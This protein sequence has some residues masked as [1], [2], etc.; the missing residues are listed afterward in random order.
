M[1]TNQHHDACP[2]NSP[3]HHAVR[4]QTERV[5][6]IWVQAVG[7]GDACRRQGQRGGCDLLGP[8]HGA[9][10]PEDSGRCWR[11]ALGWEPG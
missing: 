10:I 2:P 6:G 9:G 4:V 7:Q 11:C 3:A 5:V 1:F 8:S